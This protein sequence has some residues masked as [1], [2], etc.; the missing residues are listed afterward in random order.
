MSCDG[1]GEFARSVSSCG[2]CEYSVDCVLSLKSIDSAHISALPIIQIKN[3]HV[4][5]YVVKYCGNS[6]LVAVPII[7]KVNIAAR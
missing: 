3:T 7:L 4:I 1:C 2:S 6:V 5:T